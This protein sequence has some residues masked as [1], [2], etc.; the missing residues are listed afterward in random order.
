MIA[1]RAVLWDMDGT[2]VDSEQL[3]WLAWQQ[4]MNAEGAPITH[5]QFLVS[6]GRRNDSV[7]PGWLGSKATP[8]L[9]ARISNAKDALY[10]E[11]V[12][13]NGIS[14]EPG[15][16]KWIHQ[17]NRNGWQQAIASSAPRLN[18]EVIVDVL[19]FT[20]QFQAIVSAEDVKKGKPDPEVY[21]K[22]AERVGADSCRC[23]VVED[24]VPGLMG[25][26]AAGMR[27][28]GVSHH[29]E[30]MPADLVVNS[31][32]QLKADAFDTLLNGNVSAG[33]STIDGLLAGS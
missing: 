6:F 14:A 7:L 5:E 10:R 1:R 25:A 24:A 28:I 12:R 18:V 9:V 17:L 26:R 33:F 20:G 8:E 21:L 4:I 19:G 32:E 23:V 16:T 22:A 15:V 13:S 2:L 11:L 3:H 29:G 30:S 27:S 31:L